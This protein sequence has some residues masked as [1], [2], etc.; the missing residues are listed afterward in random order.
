MIAGGGAVVWV[1][2]TDNRIAH[3]SVTTGSDEG[4]AIAI[5]SGLRGDERVVSAFVGRLAE[6][7]PVQVA[8]ASAP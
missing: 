6:G 4:D 5:T 8:A 3:V 2:G 7:A 1:V